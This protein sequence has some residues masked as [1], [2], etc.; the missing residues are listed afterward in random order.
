MLRWFADSP[1]NGQASG[2]SEPAIQHH[3]TRG[4]RPA[5]QHA[6]L[7]TQ[8]RGCEV[9]KLAKH[10]KSIRRAV[11]EHSQC[12]HRATPQKLPRKPLDYPSEARG[13]MLALLLALFSRRRISYWASLH[14][15]CQQR[16]FVA[17]GHESSFLLIYLRKRSPW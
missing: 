16:A 17:K 11:A 6:S 7:I 4:A 15:K 12:A 14:Q 8:A 5:A 2:S 3:S 1:I 9:K 13:I 10:S